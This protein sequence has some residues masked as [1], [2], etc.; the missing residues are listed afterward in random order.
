MCIRDRFEL[1]GKELGGQ[2][3]HD[4]ASSVP[5]N[6]ISTS[7]SCLGGGFGGGGIVHCVEFFP[8]DLIRLI[9]LLV[10]IL[11]ILEQTRLISDLLSAL[12]SIV[13]LPDDL[14]VLRALQSDDQNLSSQVVNDGSGVTTSHVLD[15]VEN[16]S[17]LAHSI[18]K[19]LSS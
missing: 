15:L 1:G 2:S 11:L 14:E 19:V 8:E 4:L 9:V 5:I 18:V 6:V 13:D 3:A 17:A 12:A 10:S 7:S 16:G